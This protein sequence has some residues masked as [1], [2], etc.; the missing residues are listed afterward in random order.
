MKTGKS[1]GY[2]IILIMLLCF[3]TA[4]LPTQDT[5]KVSNSEV[6][7]LIERASEL[8]GNKP[9]EAMML[10]QKA[11]K[12]SV[13]KKDIKGI[14]ESQN[15]IGSLHLFLGEDEQALQLYYKSL[16]LSE[17]QNDDYL[18]STT[19]NHIAIVY[20]SQ[21]KSELAIENFKKSLQY[22]EKSGKDNQILNNLYKLGVIYETLDSLQE[23]Y[24]YYKRSYLI[25]EDN[26]NTEGMFY[27][28]LGIGSVSAKRKD[29]YQAYVIYSKAKEIA[30]KLEV[31]A[32]RM[33]VYRHMGEL[34]LREK[35]YMQAREM[36]L[37][38][39]HVADSLEY[40]K[41][42]RDCYINLASTNESLKFYT[43]A[44]YYL[45]RY[46]G[47]NDTLFTQEA[48]EKLA[49]MQV[50][51]DLKNKEKEIEILKQTEQKGI[52]V[53]NSLLAGIS[54]VGLLVF[55]MIYLYRT[56]NRNNRLLK[57]RN[58]E[59][60]LQ[61]EEIYTNLDQLA[62]VNLQLSQKNQQITESIE[63]ALTVQRTMLPGPGAIREI[64]GDV[65]K[66]Y[67]PRDIVSGDFYWLHS[68]DTCNMLAIVDCTGH[69]IAGALMSV[70]ANTLM[71][72]I[73]EENPDAGV[74]VFM[75]SLSTKIKTSFQNN[76]NDP[77][78]Y[79]E[80]MDMTLI[81]YDKRT[82]RYQ[83]AMANQVACVVTGEGINVLQGDMYS[84]GGVFSKASEYDF[85]VYD[86]N[87]TTPS[88][89]Y[90]FT[91]GYFDQ[92]GGPENRKMMFTRMRDKMKTI[93]NLPVDRQKQ[94]L[95][96]YHHEWMGK[97]KQTDDILMVG[98]LVTP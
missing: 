84:I 50:R 77:G 94:E 61:K 4:W 54:L 11:L 33:L 29:Y 64:F 32:Y 88:M 95:I 66:I 25:E 51:Y 62:K 58:N 38:A 1:A 20:Q 83:I 80:G 22:A 81:R 6:A 5:K 79:D 60:Q 40:N 47:I 18:I 12:L 34:F 41:E 89:I 85:R 87:I 8:K 91:D 10:A 7:G 37:N 9:Q 3:F 73:I 96:E 17:Q 26:K 56:K 48:S 69:G 23:A 71:N 75:N 59:I 93:W 82:K 67:I 55:L 42:K 52:I 90:L 97:N 19:Y 30:D 36:F 31:M 63:Y 2:S 44:Y 24:K 74:N 14:I 68:C 92:I 21:K 15:L 43:D 13:E 76:S 45:A 35:K 39:L 98:I 78:R 49:L 27:S 70:I 86:L 57:E 53:R 16:E 65:F 72:N 28:L 46:V